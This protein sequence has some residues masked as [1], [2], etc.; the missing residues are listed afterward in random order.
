MIK[1]VFHV[2]TNTNGSEIEE[3]MEFDDDIT[4]E[5]LDEEY[6]EWLCSNTNQSYWKQSEAE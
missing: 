5:E 3:T 1:Y 4:E 2:S 6:R